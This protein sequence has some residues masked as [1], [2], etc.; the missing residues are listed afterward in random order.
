MPQTSTQRKA[1]SSTHPPKPQVR[2]HRLFGQLAFVI[3]V[4]L[5]IGAGS[6][7]GLIFVYSSNLPQVSELFDF[8][9][10]VTTELYA[11]NGAVIGSFALQRR[12]MVTYDQIPPILR[13]AIISVED[14]H[15]ES[16]FG[17]D[18]LR[19]VRSAIVDILEWRKAEGASTLT[20]QLSRRL[21]LTPEK[22]FRRKIQEALLAIQIERH[23]TKAQIF[24]MYSNLVDLGHGNYGFEA[25]AQFYFGKHLSQLTLPEAALLAG[26]P[27]TPTGY[28]PLLHP[29]RARERRNQVLAAMRE[30]GK[31][32]EDQ[33]RAARAAPLGLNIQRWSNTIAPYFV[34]DVRQFLEK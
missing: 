19:I 26:L 7:T 4:L 5:A 17:V 21:F 1:K 20:Q 18:I 16:H 11:S 14:R 27:K 2:S 22:S 34:E 29:E 12:V 24:T 6:L 32:T 31:I 33:Y 9:P 28:S 23:F 30:N 10:D 15:F 13:E 25:A 8:R 3:L